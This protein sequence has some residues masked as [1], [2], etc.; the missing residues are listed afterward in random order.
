MSRKKS[1]EEKERRPPTVSLRFSGEVR[2]L[3]ESM[4]KEQHRPLANLVEFIVLEYL[5]SQGKIEGEGKSPAPRGKILMREE[6]LGGSA[7]K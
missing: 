6:P 3:L 4:A 7:E 1:E 5:R 2:S